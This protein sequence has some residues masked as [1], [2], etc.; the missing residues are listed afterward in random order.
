MM[1]KKNSKSIRSDFEF[2]EYITGFKEKKGIRF[3]TDATKQIA[4]RLKKLDRELKN[5]E[6]EE[7]IF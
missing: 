5:N 1:A 4:R 2:I 3:D 6:E 7:F